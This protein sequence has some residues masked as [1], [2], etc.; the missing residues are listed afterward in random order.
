[1]PDKP[2]RS[3]KST[4]QHELWKNRLSAVIYGLIYPAFLGNMIYDLL[5][6]IRTTTKHPFTFPDICICGVIV[7]FSTV[8]Y[9]HLT[10]DMNKIV[11]AEKRSLIYMLADALMPFFLFGGF[12]CFKEEH[13]LTGTLLIGGIPGLLLLYKFKNKPSRNFFYWYAGVSILLGVMLTFTSF[14]YNRELIL[15]IATFSLITYVIY[16]VWI[17]PGEPRTF[18]LE[19][20]QNNP[21]REY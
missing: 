3:E 19:Y 12:V 21:G 20:F 13:Y 8:D 4:V 7:L 18:D 2:A 15:A 6:G 14:T 10:G 1:M 9:L 16:I 17:Y 5:L 11:P